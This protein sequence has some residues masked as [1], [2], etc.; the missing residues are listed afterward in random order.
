LWADVVEKVGAVLFTRFS[1]AVLPLPKA[2]DRL[3]G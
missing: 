1:G 3:V 2:H